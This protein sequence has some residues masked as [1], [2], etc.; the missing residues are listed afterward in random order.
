[1]KTIFVGFGAYVGRI[2]NRTTC[3]VWTDDPTENDFAADSLI[4]VDLGK[5]VNAAMSG[6]I[7]WSEVEVEDHV[8]SGG[9]TSIGPVWPEG[10]SIGALYLAEPLLER[11]PVRPRLPE[12]D[13]APYELQSVVY[14]AGTTDPRAGRRYRGFHAKVL[15]RRATRALVHIYQAGSSRSMPPITR[16]WLDLGSVEVC[17]VG[18]SSLSAI[19]SADEGAVFLEWNLVTGWSSGGLRN[20]PRWS[21]GRPAS[22]AP[23]DASPDRSDWLSQQPAAAGNLDAPDWWEWDVK[24]PRSSGEATAGGD[25]EGDWPEWDIKI[26]RS[27]GAATAGGDPEDD[28]PEWDVKLPRSSGQATAGG[29]PEDDWP[30]WDVKLPR[31][32]GDN[33]VPARDLGFAWGFGRRRG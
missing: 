27:S 24:I 16:Q 25:P 26:P 18:P 4:R 29:D 11:L 8:N 12:M 30:D 3:E 13:G 22:S 2:I 10:E 23:H 33:E 5:N 21:D 15:Q 17:D 1:M 19:V 31:S 20:R 9:M 14:H 6:A 7:D 28:W 32:S